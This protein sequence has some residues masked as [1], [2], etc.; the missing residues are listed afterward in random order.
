MPFSS[1]PLVPNAYV[2]SLVA[3]KGQVTTVINSGPGTIYVGTYDTVRNTDLDA[4]PIVANRFLTWDGHSNL[5]ASLP[6]GS[7]TVYKLRGVV[8]MGMI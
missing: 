8:N 2:A 6:T 3:E 7:A 4:V 1:I 5:Y